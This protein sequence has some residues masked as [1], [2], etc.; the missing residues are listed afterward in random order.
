MN[1]ARASWNTLYESKEGFACRITLRDEDEASLIPRATRVIE[2]ITRSGGTAVR[3][4]NHPSDGET[5]NCEDETGSSKP[6]ATEKTYVDGQG[7]RRCN[8][9]LKNG[10]T[11]ETPVVERNGR[12]GKFWSCPNYRN[13]AS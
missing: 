5:R 9:V 3:L 8:L 13:H 12:Y 2:G 4:R 11:C 1:E 10:K 6:K 7:I